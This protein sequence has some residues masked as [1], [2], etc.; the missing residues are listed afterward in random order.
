[1]SNTSNKKIT[2]Y[3]TTLRDGAQGLG[4]SFS[5]DD[6]LRIAA[7]LDNLKIDYIEGGW[8]GSNPKDDLFFEKIREKKLSHA[9]IVA[10]GSTRRKNTTCEEDPLIQ[11]LIA[12]KADIVA[13][14]GK[15]WDFQATTALG[16][17]PEENLTLIRDSV[18]Y[19]K[20]KGLT[21][22]MDA[23][24]YFDGFKSN[25]EYALRAITTAYESGAD[26]LVLCD[27][28]GGTLPH[29]VVPIVEETQK[30]VGGTLGV[31]FH[32]DTGVAV[33][34]S[35]AAVLAGAVSVQGT[36]NGYGERCG[37]C[38]LTTLIPNMSLKMDYK[39]A[40]A[41]TLA[42]LTEV[43]RFVSETANLVHASNMPYV[44]G[45]AFAH[46]GGIHVSALQR[47]TK[48]Y[49]HIE[50]ALVGN[51]REILISELS[52]KS[53]IEFRAKE[54]GIDMNGKP[55]LSKNI[56]D[57]IKKMEDEGFQFEA[58]GGSFE[59]IARGVTG[60]Y[61]PFFALRGFRVITEMDE[62]NTMRC[63]AT[64]KVDV[65]GKEE[66]SAADGVG[67]V[68][69]LDNA[70]RKALEK[71][72]PEI[73]DLQLTDYKVRVLNEKAGTSSKVRVLM[74]MMRDGGHWG[75]VGVSSNIIEASW[76]AMVDG[77][78]YMLFKK[79]RGRRKKG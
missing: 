47:D 62:K 8:P 37:N 10:F 61:S 41:K 49:E 65:D 63:E 18:T 67:P 71:F 23:E 21:V 27:T 7:A 35:M 3:D 57:K 42:Q 70:L 78:E 75:T 46:K 77:I 33:A 60:E 43:S 66:H 22:F 55:T 29:E 58:A 74:D 24:H 13:I 25:S 26:M 56:L 6:K 17:S 11:S 40:A 51:S 36:I 59:L 54:L 50:P 73:K 4:I 19:L 28:N 30:R 53:N 68:G 9:K 52:G 79:H 5:L 44:G 39:F 20:K 2:I 34:N 45:S 31:H 72:Y 12:S 32:N 48:T 1:M 16:I 76:Q 14:F 15:T 64:I 69:A 38:S